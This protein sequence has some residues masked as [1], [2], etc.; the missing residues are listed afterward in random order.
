MQKT[1]NFY[2]SDI[3]MTKLKNKNLTVAYMGAAMML[4]YMKREYV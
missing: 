3:K 4:T 2:I 1:K